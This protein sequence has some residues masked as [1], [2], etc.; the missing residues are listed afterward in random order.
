MYAQERTK[1]QVQEVGTGVAP[2]RL[3]RVGHCWNVGA[4]R[5]RHDGYIGTHMAVATPSILVQSIEVYIY[6]LFSFFLSW[7]S[8]TQ[9]NHWTK[10]MA[11]TRLAT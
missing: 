10:W 4:Y 5:Y 2:W 8:K 9:P 1:Q 3:W 7:V 6:P 11:N